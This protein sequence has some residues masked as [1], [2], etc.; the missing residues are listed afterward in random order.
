[1]L[2]LSAT[3]ATALLFGNCFGQDLSDGYWSLDQATEVLSKTRTVVLDP[4]ISSLTEAE[5]AVADK[6]M[7]VW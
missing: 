4:D 6:L 7:Q 5:K 2:I 3:L 1:M